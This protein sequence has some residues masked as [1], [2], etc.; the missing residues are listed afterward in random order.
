[1]KRNVYLGGQSHRDRCIMT[2]T[3]WPWHCDCC[4]PALWPLQPLWPSHHDRR[5]MTVAP[6]PSHRDHCRKPGW[7]DLVDETWWMR[8]GRWDLPVDR[9]LP[10]E[11]RRSQSCISDQRWGI[12]RKYLLIYRNHEARCVSETQYP[13]HKVSRVFETSAEV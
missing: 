1:M 12:G 8:P 3:S 11:T 4:R 7:W 5:I 6:W 9:D 2:V 13:K 10:D